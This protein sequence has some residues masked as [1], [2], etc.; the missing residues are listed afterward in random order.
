MFSV[1]L[2]LRRL[3]ASA[4]G[5]ARAFGRDQ[6]GD[7]A[8]EFGILALPFFTLVLA[9]LQTAIMF[10]STQVL[11]SALEDASR[12]IRTGQ[13]TSYTLDQFRNY[14][15]GYTFNLLDCSQ[16]Q[17]KAQVIDDFSSVDT[18]VPETC[19]YDEGTCEWTENWQAY[20]PGSGRSVMQVS[21]YY[22]YPLLVVLPYFNLKNQPDNYRLISAIRVF[23][24]EPF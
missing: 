19:D 13:A 24:N 15:C 16:I 22:R 14:M 9:I 21:A 12:R 17:L 8:I 3:A 20:D 5:R 2:T 23:R 18:T 6:T 4:L 7:T 10:L 11:D 1:R